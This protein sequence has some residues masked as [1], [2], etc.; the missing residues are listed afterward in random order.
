MAISS[1]YPDADEACV[2][3]AMAGAACGCGAGVA[4]VIVLL[5]R[6][7]GCWAV[8]IFHDGATGASLEGVLRDHVA[9]EGR[10]STRCA[11]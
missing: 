11:P 7:N 5:V 9:Q 3:E 10:R 6:Q 8:S 2:M 1:L 4:G